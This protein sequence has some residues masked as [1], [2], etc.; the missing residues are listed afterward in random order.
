MKT[1]D[2]I[3]LSMSSN[4]KKT[5]TQDKLLEIQNIS[6]RIIELSE[7]MGSIELT[8]DGIRD[9]FETDTITAVAV[10]EH[11]I[12]IGIIEKNTIQI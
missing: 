7:I 8:V 2:N 11:L 3:Q 4:F 6:K 12:F 5:F 10:I 9:G 1:I